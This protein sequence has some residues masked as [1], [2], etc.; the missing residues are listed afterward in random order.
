M[1]SAPDIQLQTAPE[2]SEEEC[3]RV[4]G[5]YL[6][7]WGQIDH[8]LRKVF[9][10]LADTN[11]AASYILF[12]GTTDAGAR[13]QIIEALGNSRLKKADQTKLASLLERAKT[14][15]GRRNRIIHG[16]WLIHIQIH[17]DKKTGKERARTATWMRA[18]APVDLEQY[19]EIHKNQKVR[20]Q[21]RYSIQTI[22]NIMNE[23]RKLAREI[24]AF[25]GSISLLP[26]FLPQPIDI[27][28]LPA[29]TPPWNPSE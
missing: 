16:D 12:Q 3:D 24:D 18:Y 19:D 5:A 23:T 25:A 11:Q 15:A 13:R 2:P 29:G 21:Y 4:L 10:K 8:A 22:I 17:T 14:A 9:S 20:N 27:G 28:P 1:T 7:S 6:R 26:F